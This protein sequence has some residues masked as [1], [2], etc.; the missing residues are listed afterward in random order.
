MLLYLSFQT[1][2]FNGVQV[3]KYEKNQTDGKF[4]STFH[5]RIRG[6]GNFHSHL[7]KISNIYFCL[8]MLVDATLGGSESRNSANLNGLGH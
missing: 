2:H 3:C 8:L 6:F 1:F 7:S 5:Q 4:K